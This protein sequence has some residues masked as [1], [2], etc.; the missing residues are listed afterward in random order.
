MGKHT[1]AQGPEGTA[2]APAAAPAMEHGAVGFEP[3]TPTRGAATAARDG[4]TAKAVARDG[5]GAAGDQ[6][7]PR[8]KR[9]LRNVLSTIF[10]VVGIALL[11]TAGYLYFHAQSEYS[12]TRQSNEKL[13]K[14]ANVQ[15]SED[16]GAPKIDFAALE[17]V[18]DD[19]VGWVDVVG[20]S[21]S[22]PVYQGKTNNT[23]LRT[24][25]TGEYSVGGQVFLDCKNT[26]PGM[27]DAQS[28]IYGHHLND[29]QMFAPLDDLKKQENFDKVKTVWYVDR[30]NKAWELEPL[31]LYIIK[32]DYDDDLRTF[33]FASNDDFHAYLNKMLAKAVAK[34][35]DAQQVIGGTSHVLTLVT[36]NYD[37]GH[38]RAV[39]LCVPKSEAAAATGASAQD[40]SASGATDGA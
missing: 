39:M 11:A 25:A 4:H 30:N 6:G 28:L 24:S 23:Y 20:T 5:H 40:A 13:Q 37:F 21:M 3:L 8:R 7:R 38:G 10:L 32:S 36:C 12:H 27:V 9:G 18:N 29:G 31:L 15:V 2:Q 35:S 1:R 17:A 22:F 33:T 26:K 16:N 34:R 19:I 14:V